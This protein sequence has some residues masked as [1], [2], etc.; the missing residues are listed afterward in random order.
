MFKDNMETIILIHG[1]WMRGLVLLPQQ[2]W[3]R[4]EGFFAHRFSYP[5]WGNGLAA[6]AHL[7]SGFVNNT[8]G[9]V[10]HLVAHS[11]GGLVALD[12]LTHEPDIRIGRVVLMGTPYMGCH[13]G[14]TL[15]RLSVLNMLVGRTFK[16]FFR[17]PRP[18]L[19]TEVEIG[20]IAGTR[21]IGLGRLVPR[22]A[23][24]NDGLV[25]V[26][27]THISAAKDSITLNVSHSG[28]LLS[29]RCARQI[30]NF[31]RTGNFIHA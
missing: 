15:A 23:R 1:L 18:I 7:L 8:P 6:N 5:S 25:A 28:M 22:L 21:S 29:R 9:S 14:T 3:L 12:M 2:R 10:I 30:G 27:E 26:S 20:V 16:D 11:L 24:P 31:L 4:A 17:K 13:C 19:H